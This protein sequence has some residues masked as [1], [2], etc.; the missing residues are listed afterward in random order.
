MI[1]NLADV[2]EFSEQSYLNGT[3]FAF[4]VFGDPGAALADLGRP[5]FILEYNAYYLQEVQE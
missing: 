1:R 3:K 2:E 5:T 4:T